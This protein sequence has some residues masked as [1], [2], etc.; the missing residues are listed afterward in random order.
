[1]KTCNL[2]FAGS[3]YLNLLIPGSTFAHSA[4]ILLSIIVALYAILSSQWSTDTDEDEYVEDADMA[5][6]DCA[7]ADAQCCE[8]DASEPGSQAP[9]S[10]GKSKRT[11]SP[12][13]FSLAGMR[14]VFV[15][16]ATGRY[17]WRKYRGTVK[18]PKQA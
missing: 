18:A 9:A 17:L 5:A 2:L 1:M 4:V 3:T 12:S 10:T 13:I 16:F 14:D 15:D 7:P 8:A 11:A 6:A